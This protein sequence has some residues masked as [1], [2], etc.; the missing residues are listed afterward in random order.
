MT[1][2]EFYTSNNQGEKTNSINVPSSYFRRLRVVLLGVPKGRIKGGR[3]VY[4]NKNDFNRVVEV[5]AT[6]T[7]I[8]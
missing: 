4:V 5:L 3:K 1:T 2:A 8:R 6:G 7:K